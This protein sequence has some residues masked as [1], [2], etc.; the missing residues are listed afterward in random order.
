MTDIKKYRDILL[1]VLLGLSLRLLAFLLV[2]PWL[3]E[4]MNTRILVYDALGYHQLGLEI[5]NSLSF[6]STFRTPGYP[7][8]IAMIYTLFGVKPWA[9]VLAQTFIDT[10]TIGVIYFS[11]SRLF[12]RN[13][14]LIASLFYP[15]RPSSFIPCSNVELGDLVH[16]LTVCGR[17]SAHYRITGSK[18]FQLSYLRPLVRVCR[19]DQT[20]RSVSRLHLRCH[21]LNNATTAR[22]AQKGSHFSDLCP[23]F[24]CGAVPVVMA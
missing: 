6:N 2:K 16:I 12:S 9:V 15:D 8:F 18:S 20:H 5:A 10:L 14:G 13:S 7:M 17:A 4:I 23:E 19:S 22:N 24:L 11:G 21:H 3:P 1:I